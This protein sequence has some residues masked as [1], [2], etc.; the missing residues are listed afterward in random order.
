MR[1]SGRGW[2]VDDLTKPDLGAGGLG[3]SDECEPESGGAM[4]GR[5]QFG[6]SASPVG[7]RLVQ[8]PSS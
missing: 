7:Q 1:R 6:R 2:P 3:S 8:L 4:V 5:A